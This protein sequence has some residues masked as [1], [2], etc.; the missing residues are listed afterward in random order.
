MSIELNISSPAQSA[1]TSNESV[2]LADTLHFRFSKTD[3]SEVENDT[4]KRRFELL[5]ER[6]IGL[7]DLT[8]EEIKAFALCLSHPTVQGRTLLFFPEAFKIT[9]R[10]QAVVSPAEIIHAFIRHIHG[11]WGDWGE[12][13]QD[14][15]LSHNEAAL[16]RKA[17]TVESCF[18]FGSSPELIVATY[19]RSSL[20]MACLAADYP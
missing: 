13:H 18:Q 11:D 20:T 9:K 5:E 4:I 15:I 19:P 14:T 1:P 2:A 8:V 10:L 16:R 6:K 17:G 12:I 3:T 7:K